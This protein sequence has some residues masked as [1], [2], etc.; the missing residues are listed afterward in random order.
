[1]SFEDPETRL[2][3]RLAQYFS[4]TRELRA[5]GAPELTD[6]SRGSVIRGDTMVL[7]RAGESR[8]EDLL[9]VTGR[10]PHATL[11][12]G[13]ETPVDS[14]AGDSTSPSEGI[15]EVEG[16]SAGI[17]PEL[18][19]TVPPLDTL[20]VSDTAGVDPLAVAPMD[21]LAVPDTAGVDPQDLT[22][23]DSVVQA[24]QTPPDSLV[25]AVRAPPDSGQAAIRPP[26]DSALA[27]ERPRDPENLTPDPDDP[28]MER[29]PAAPRF[30]PDTTATPYEVDARRMVLQGRGFFSATGAVLIRRDSME[31]VADSVEYDQ[32]AGTLFLSREARLHME[33]YDLTADS[34]WLDVPGDELRNVRARQYAVIEGEQ[35]Q[36]LAPRIIIFLTDGEME[37]LVA[38]R[39]TAMDSLA[40]G[41]GLPPRPHPAAR[42]WGLGRFPSRPHAVAEDFLLWADSIEVL[43][44]GEVLEELWAIGEA[45]GESMARDSLNQEDT[46]ELIRRDWLEGDTIIATFAETSDSSAAPEDSLVV[47]E[48]NP[49]LLQEAQGPPE[50]DSSESRYRLEQLVARAS[51]RSLYRLEPSDS[52]VL[53]EDAR[54]A[55]HYVVGD[56]ITIL[57]TEGEVERMEVVGTT[58]GVHL[59]PISRG[60]EG[61]AQA[62]TAST[63]GRGGG[64]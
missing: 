59:E 36:L 5:W 38:I 17:R 16:E 46:P 6:L 39:D 24:V 12:P 3:S 18:A 31:A 29:V 9:T 40:A 61:G 58:R 1:V 63:S 41:G 47:A 23:L 21:T 15:P 64:G 11:Y 25:A 34:I 20:A 4:Q 48:P 60:R 44:P 43:A 22:P 51:A 56:E 62:D 54:L 37:R 10:R 30:T 55:V 57:F 52:T 26:P 14:V 19:D 35:I 7:L 27:A 13:A 42:Q 45:R 8:P 32:S 2:T 33:T 53:D 50:A 49:E 28:E